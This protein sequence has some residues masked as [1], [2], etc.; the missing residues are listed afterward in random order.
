MN[1]KKLW[2]ILCM[3]ALLLTSSA[4]ADADFVLDE[5]RA[6]SGMNRSYL[7]GYVP[8]V[9][10]DEMT[11]VLPLTSDSAHGSIQAKIVPKDMAHSPFKPQ[12]FKISVKKK[13]F[14]FG[15]NRVYAYRAAFKLK[16][17]PD[18]QNGEYPFSVVVTG[19]D[20]RGRALSQTFEMEAVIRD[21]QS[22]Q[23]PQP[24][25]CSARV[26]GGCVEAG[27]RGVL[28]LEIENQSA[29]RAVERLSA[30][31]SEGE[32]N[33]M[34][35]ESDR[36]DIGRMAVGEKRIVQIPL[37][38]PEQAKAGIHSLKIVLSYRDAQGTEG[39]IT[40][41]FPIEVRR[42]VR[43]EHSDPV[44]PAKIAQGET[45]A[46][47]IDLM[48]M[49]GCVLSNVLLKFDLPGLSSGGSVL[50][51]SINPG[52]TRQASANFR[53]DEAALGRVQ[54]GVTISY[55]DEYGQLHEETLALSTE[56]VPKRA[57]PAALEADNEETPK[58]TPNAGI[59]WGV[60]A[61]LAVLTAAQGIILKRKIRRLEEKNL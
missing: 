47:R 16:L 45:P 51:G 5:R 44:L 32:N 37:I 22:G 7:Q 50:A 4:W 60:A 28:Q 36:V 2:L 53:V 34:T 57:A 54:G 23:A 26:Q 11:V 49:G 21:G 14:R 52:E 15:K 59:G 17:H 48:N 56:I 43:L 61:V 9:K 33:L 41:S 18:R 35:A 42:R 20:K 6:Y 13:R 46:F 1:M 31:V 25:I 58:R 10:G 38:A 24:T 39:S 8:T 3:G 12:N 55:E 27:D 40:Q 19:R 29:Y 30:T